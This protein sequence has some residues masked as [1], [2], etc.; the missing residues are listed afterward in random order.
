MKRSPHFSPPSGGL[1]PKCHE[2]GLKWQHGFGGSSSEPAEKA[3]FEC[4]ICGE[5]SG[6][7]F[8][9]GDYADYLY[10]CQRDRELDRL[11]DEEGK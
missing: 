6:E 2:N 4:Q 8:D 5:W 3:G 7:E 9:P 10:E 1:C 11:L